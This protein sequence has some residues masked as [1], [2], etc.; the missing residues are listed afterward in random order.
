MSEVSSGR[1]RLGIAAI[2]TTA[3]A[4]PLT[5]SI[6]YAQSEAPQTPAAPAAPQTPGVTL[7]PEAPQSPAPPAP[8]SAA[9]MDRDGEHVIVHVDDESGERRVIRH[10]IMR[11]GSEH[12]DEEVEAMMERIEA[13]MEGREAEI[14]AQVMAAHQ[15]AQQAADRAM[16]A[17]QRAMR[18]RERAE[19]ARVMAMRLED[20][21]CDDADAR[22]VLE[23]DLGN[24]R[25]ATVICGADSHERIARESAQ[26]SMEAAIVGLRAALES[27]RGNAMIPASERNEAVRGMREAIRE[28][29][30]ETR[31][32]RRTQAKAEGLPHS[33]AHPRA[34]SVAVRWQ[35]PAESYGQAVAPIRF[36]IPVSAIA[37]DAECEAESLPRVR[38]T[39]A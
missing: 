15:R 18:G 29:E 12:I 5:A 25:K 30:A 17:E 3:L 22:G 21:D 27:I 28:L 4:L 34:T 11:D 38:I 9:M 32:L 31:N 37:A 26:M 33:A 36:T 35:M 6:T 16:Q 39:R 13:E 14:E 23:R 8:P 24:G 7:A 10:R 1:R 19:E 2:T 20:F